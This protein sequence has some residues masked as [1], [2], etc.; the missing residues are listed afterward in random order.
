VAECCRIVLISSTPTSFVV[1]MAGSPS[2][3]WVGYEGGEIVW[4]G[5]GV[6]RV[7]L[8]LYRQLVLVILVMRA[9]AK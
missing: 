5:W 9:A 6:A 8:W 1:F 7:V 3:F 2:E 4:L